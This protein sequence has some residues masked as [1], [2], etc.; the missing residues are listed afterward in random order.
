MSG[1]WWGREAPPSLREGHAGKVPE[2]LPADRAALLATLDGRRA[3]F[4][5]EWTSRGPDDAGMALRQLFGEQLEAVVQR[6]NRWPDKAITAFLS[7]AGVELM[8]GAP[9]E[10]LLAFTV[11]DSAPRSVLI[12]P[13]FQAGA[14][15]PGV[16]T[17]A[18]FETQDALYA[19]PGAIGEVFV[20]DPG[21][22]AAIDPTQPFAP[23][24]DPPTSNTALLI[25]LTSPAAPSVTL[26]FGLGVAAPAGAPPPVG[27]GGVAPL[28]V[29][30]GPA[31]IWEVLDGAHYQVLN[32]NRDETA[33][34][35]RSGLVELDLPTE[36]RPGLPVG[37]VDA[38]STRWVRLR[39]AYGQFSTTPRLA[40]LALNMARAL[41]ARTIRDEVPT[42]M[43]ASDGRRLQLS[44]VPVVPG[45]LQLDIDESGLQGGATMRWNPVPDLA[46]AGP[47]DAVFE[48]DVVTG[49]LR[50][51]NGTNG[52]ALPQGYRNV[53]A[54]RYQAFSAVP[55]QVEAKGIVVPITPVESVTKVENP[56]AS[57]GGG[58][59]ETVPQ[60][61]ARGPLEIRTRWRAVAPAD[62]ALLALHAAGAQVAR[63][64]AVPGL[65]A[66]YPGALIPGVVGV[67]VV[68]P[69]SGDGPP[70]PG[71]ET[72]RG[73]ATSLA[74]AAAPA[75]VEVVTAAPSYQSVG[76]AVG[77]VLADGAD[78]GAAATALLQAL[79]TYLHPLNGGDDGAGWPFGGTIS[80]TRLLRR[81]TAVPGV[82][83]A[84]R[85]NVVLDGIRQPSC[86]DVPIQPNALLWPVGH[87]VLILDPGA[88]S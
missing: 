71:P 57:S 42:P 8:P 26:T 29:P 32:V 22:F 31:L 85:L 55:D 30:L 52:R 69:V 80:Y 48:L 28:P 72:L 62:Y 74:A 13:G 60:A 10:A 46:A 11:A 17:L 64:Y 14:R 59:G 76:V 19:A 68:P 7:G 34:L 35:A 44:Q 56:L 73:L 36:W 51:G 47:E 75:G 1:A 5:P 78:A 39:V 24:G 63:A 4:T 27:A 50:F 16:D 67:I 2:L 38:K 41:G 45:S 53:H 23:F 65:H 82:R 86:Q 70:V 25:G 84:P 58:P 83:A 87:Q 15:I 9:A 54:T 12:A 40:Y 18:V 88:A 61:L 66:A 33:G 6:L 81:I 3:T 49:E 21:S 37:L 79:D 43:P 77:V 20:G